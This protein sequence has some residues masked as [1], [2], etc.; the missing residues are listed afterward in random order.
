MTAPG[1]EPSA[2]RAAHARDRLA[3]DRRVAALDVDIRIVDD[4]VFLSGTVNTDGQRALAGQL[5]EEALPELTLHNELVIVE[6][7][8]APVEHREHLA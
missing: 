2:Y 3:S 5:I 7:R 6:G 4:K 1:S 8:E